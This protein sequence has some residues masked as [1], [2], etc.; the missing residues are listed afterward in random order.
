MTQKACVCRCET[1][2]FVRSAGRGH[3]AAEGRAQ[4]LQEFRVRKGQEEDIWLQLGEW[5]WRDD[6]AAAAVYQQVA[7]S[8]CGHAG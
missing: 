6:A 8:Y 3:G 4:R 2:S 5:A 7:H 1:C